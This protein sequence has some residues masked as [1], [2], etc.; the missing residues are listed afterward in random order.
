MHLFLA[1][2]LG[3]AAGAGARYLVNVAAVHLLG[4]AFPWA[5]LFVNVAGSFLMGLVV[6]VSESLL[7]GS[8]LARTFLATG[9]LGGF[10]TFSAFSLDAV[11]LY[12]RHQAALAAVYVVASVAIS[13][14]A[15]VAGLA[16]AKAVAS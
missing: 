8:A 2:A 5:T 1:A 12:E 15:L 10:T 16:T 3:G 7:G 13:I 9:I 14:A 11:S 4:P 6:G